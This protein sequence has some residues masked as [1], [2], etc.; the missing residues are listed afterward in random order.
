ME[1]LCFES[2]PTKRV[3]LYSSTLNLILFLEHVFKLSRNTVS[4][5][6][7][8]FGLPCSTSTLVLL[9]NETSSA[10]HLLFPTV[11]A[12][13]S[14]GHVVKLVLGRMWLMTQAAQPGKEDP[15]STWTSLG[16]F[17]R[18]TH[19]SSPLLS[20]RLASLTPL[21]EPNWR[22][23]PNAAGL[24]LHCYVVPPCPRAST[25][26]PTRVIWSEVLIQCAWQ[27]LSFLNQCCLLL[28]DLLQTSFLPALSQE[29]ASPLQRC[30]HFMTAGFVPSPFSLSTSSFFSPNSPLAPC[31][32]YLW[33]NIKHFREAAAQGNLL[34]RF[35]KGGMLQAVNILGLRGSQRP[36]SSRSTGWTS[37]SH[38]CHLHRLIAE[39]QEDPEPG[40]P[41]PRGGQAQE[42]ALPPLC[43]P[44]TPPAQQTAAT[45]HPQGSL[46]LLEVCLHGLAKPS[47]S[48]CWKS[49]EPPSPVN[50]IAW[51]LGQMM[52]AKAA[53]SSTRGFSDTHKVFP[54]LFLWDHFMVITTSGNSNDSFSYFSLHWG[55]C[56][57]FFS[58]LKMWLGR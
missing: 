45:G 8:S 9:L 56:F 7:Y 41:S 33:F 10:V 39:P 43:L 57:F 50:L 23:Q 21:E 44:S 32:N 42:E 13:N 26:S 52:W 51:K 49:P 11:T 3:G 19:C 53:P 37:S 34:C 36:G 15:Q 20:C 40:E 48:P 4:T 28:L 38:L 25:S 24:S 35:R 18:P 30:K 12:L 31:S 29:T 46:R 17:A 27:N 22:L 54:G 1:Y 55:V 14:T 47:Q 2:F 16:I 6:H 58:W 5:S